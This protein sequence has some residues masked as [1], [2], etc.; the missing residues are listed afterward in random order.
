MN[1][2]TKEWKFKSDEKNTLMLSEWKLPPN[3]VYFN[4]IPHGLYNILQ[5]LN[6]KGMFYKI[7]NE[8]FNI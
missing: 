1:E 3:M 4:K 2:F 8:I 6:A 7:F 5:T